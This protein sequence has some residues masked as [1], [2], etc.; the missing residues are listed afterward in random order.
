MPIDFSKMPDQPTSKV[1][2]SKMPDQPKGKVD[3]SKMPDQPT[4]IGS[5]IS[6]VAGVAIGTLNAPTAFV[7]GSQEAQHIDPE[8]YKE[9][10]V[11]ER[12]LV[13]FG[14]GFD[15]A[16]RSITKKGDFGTLYGEYRKTKTG[17]TIRQETLDDLNVDN[18]LFSLHLV[19]KMTVLI[20][21]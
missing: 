6:R 3:F 13:D 17:K 5:G 9:M 10:P 16:R 14:G 4:S 19:Y 2:F 7:W 12:L 18:L 11:W 8:Q 20:S 15:S 1:D 21:V